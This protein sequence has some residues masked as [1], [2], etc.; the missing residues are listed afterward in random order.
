MAEDIVVTQ[1]VKDVFQSIRKCGAGDCEFYVKA[2]VVDK[3]TFDVLVE[4]AALEFVDELEFAISARDRP[5]IASIL[6]HHPNADIVYRL[7][8]NDVPRN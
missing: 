7:L 1:D 2:E 3:D 6:K 4:L 8:L 5:K